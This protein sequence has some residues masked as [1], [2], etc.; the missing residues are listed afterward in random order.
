VAE[1]RTKPDRRADLLAAARAVLAEKGLEAATVSE[2]VARAGV[3]QGTFYLYFPSKMALIPALDEELDERILAAVREAAARA[4]SA[5]EVVNMGVTAAFQELE[6]Y[7]DVLHV[8]HSRITSLS[9]ESDCEAQFG[10]YHR[11]VTELIR[12]RQATGEIDATVNPEISARLIIGLIN[13]AADECYI[14]NQQVRPEVYIAE[15]IRFVSRAL[16]VS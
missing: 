11:L 1:I 14:H 7:R 4:T 10:P 3:A 13:H 15:V 16:G 12:Q 2:I 6:R 8:I 5:A 9:P